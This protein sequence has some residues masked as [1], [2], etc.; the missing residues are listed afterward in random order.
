VYD[1]YAR[2]EFAELM[3]VVRITTARF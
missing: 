2:T 3:S 1:G